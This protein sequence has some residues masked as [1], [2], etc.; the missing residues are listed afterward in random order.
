MFGSNLAAIIIPGIH[1][2]Q[3]GVKVWGTKIHNNASLPL[4]FQIAVKDDTRSLVEGLRRH[5]NVLN[6][7]PTVQCQGQN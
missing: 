5:K 1:K 2:T 7:M 6:L 3:A 4:D